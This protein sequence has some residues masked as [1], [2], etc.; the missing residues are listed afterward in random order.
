MVKKVLAAVVLA[1]LAIFSVPA[2]ANAAGYVPDSAIAVSGDVVPG[3]TVTV[4]FPAN[5]FLAGETVQ[6]ALTGE[7]TPTLSVVKAATATA[8]GTA[9]ST[10]AASVTVG[11]PSDASGTYNGSATGLSSGNVATW[12]LFVSSSSDA[13]GL[14]AT[15]YEFPSMLLWSA[16]GALLIGIALLVVLVMARRRRHANSDI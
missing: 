15:G 6:F 9:T 16:A 4:G 13:T 12:T 1:I 8:N 2:L 14:P 11:L 10:G 7:G 5:S 3:G